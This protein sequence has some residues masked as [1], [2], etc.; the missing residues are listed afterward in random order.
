MG[1]AIRHNKSTLIPEVRSHY[2]G[3]LYD[4]LFD[5]Y[6]VMRPASSGL[7]LPYLVDDLLTLDDFAEHAV[8]PTLGARRGVIEN[9]V[10][11]YVD[12]KL[13]GC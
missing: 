2:V 5:G 1:Q 7:D 11:L 6:V 8:A 13:T 3:S 12:E 4:D 9:S 10:V